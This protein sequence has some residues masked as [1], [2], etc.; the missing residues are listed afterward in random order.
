M[1]H[2]FTP[3]DC[4]SNE[5]VIKAEKAELVQSVKPNPKTN[6]EDCLQKDFRKV[7][8]ACGFQANIHNSQQFVFLVEQKW[9][10]NV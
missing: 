8:S 6:S 4:L 3:K 1:L 9:I 7:M 5:L 10:F 2:Q